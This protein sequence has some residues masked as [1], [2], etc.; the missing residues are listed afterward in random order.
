MTSR[1]TLAKRLHGRTFASLIGVVSLIPVLTF[2]AS[3]HQSSESAWHS[4]NSPFQLHQIRYGPGSR[5]TPVMGGWTV[6]TYCSQEG[7]NASCMKNRD[8]PFTRRMIAVVP[9]P[10]IHRFTR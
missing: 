6:P 3:R 2:D 10:Q 8:T 9:K 7:M 5:R 4:W 1:R